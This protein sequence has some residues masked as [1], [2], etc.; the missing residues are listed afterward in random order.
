MKQN[1][2]D[3]LRNNLHE[4]AESLGNLLPG[5]DWREL[6]R[7]MISRSLLHGR[8]RAEEMREV[9]ATVRQAGLEPW[10]SI[11]CAERQDWAADRADAAGVV[12][13]DALLDQLLATVGNPP[14]DG[15]C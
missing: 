11:A 12:Q 9:A 4:L 15:A 1:W 14:G 10:M 5:T 2:A 8:R 7:Y 6:S 13:L 3:T